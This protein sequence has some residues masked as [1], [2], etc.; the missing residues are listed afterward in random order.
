M[1]YLCRDAPDRC[2]SPADIAPD[3]VGTVQRPEQQIGAHLPRIIRAHADLLTDDAPLPSDRVRR[4]VQ[5]RDH[6]QQ[7]TQCPVKAAGSA[8]RT[9]EQVDR[10]VIGRVGVDLRA[11]RGKRRLGVPAPCRLKHFMLQEVR[12]ACRFAAGTVEGTAGYAQRGIRSGHIL[13][14]DQDAQSGRVARLVVTLTQ[15]RAFMQPE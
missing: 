12:N 6:A 4:D 2:L 8:L 14:A 5:T 7:S 3:R 10:P 1:Q 9:G 13:R 15:L 11:Q